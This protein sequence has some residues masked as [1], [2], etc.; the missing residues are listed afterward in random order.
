MLATEDA[1]ISRDSTQLSSETSESMARRPGQQQ[2]KVPV[3]RAE[4]ALGGGRLSL[5]SRLCD[6]HP[7][8]ASNKYPTLRFLVSTLTWC[9]SH[10]PS[11]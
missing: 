9:F 10:F 7:E 1:A 11:L 4:S 6:S 8:H 2:R 3:V 5:L